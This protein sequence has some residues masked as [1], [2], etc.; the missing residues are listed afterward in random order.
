MQQQLKTGD[1]NIPV[2]LKIPNVLNLAFNLDTKN[3]ET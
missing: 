2:G 3:T 1:R